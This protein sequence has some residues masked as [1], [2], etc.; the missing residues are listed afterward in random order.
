MRRSLTVWLVLVGLL[1][2]ALSAG[3]VSHAQSDTPATVTSGTVTVTLSVNRVVQLVMEECTG[4][5][6]DNGKSNGEFMFAFRGYIAA[7]TPWA[8]VVSNESPP[9]GGPAVYRHENGEDNLLASPL[10]V[11]EGTSTHRYSFVHV[12]RVVCPDYLTA[13][14]AV[15]AI[16]YQVIPR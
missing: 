10:V 12:Y 13:R 4:V 14:R 8:L 7:N 6:G 9:V 15:E 1:P 16:R 2:A 5:S 11:A 3:L